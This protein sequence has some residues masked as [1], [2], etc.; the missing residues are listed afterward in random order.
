MEIV[1]FRLQIRDCGLRNSK[2]VSFLIKRKPPSSLARLADGG[3]GHKVCS[4]TRDFVFCPT[5]IGRKDAK[6][7]KRKIKILNSI[8]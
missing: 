8:I 6:K 2:L 7:G 3:E 1:D 4:K 5:Y